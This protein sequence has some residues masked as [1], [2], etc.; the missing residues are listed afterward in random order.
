[1]A[2]PRA[3]LRCVPGCSTRSTWRRRCPRRRQ[4]GGLRRTECCSWRRLLRPAKV[5]RR[6]SKRLVRVCFLWLLVPLRCSYFGRHGRALF[7]GLARTDR[8]VVCV[9]SASSLTIF[10]RALCC[11]LHFTVSAEAATRRQGRLGPGRRA[12]R[13]CVQRGRKEEVLLMHSLVSAARSRDV[14]PLCALSLLGIIRG[15][16]RSGELM[17]WGRRAPVRFFSVSVSGSAGGFS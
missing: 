13:H 12:S 8:A 9:D 14:A 2:C 11:G 15:V 6:S 17:V 7:V 5:S 1:M 3:C 16:V 10:R 4:R